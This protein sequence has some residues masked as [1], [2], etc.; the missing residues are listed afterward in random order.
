[1]G[2]KENFNQAVYELFGVGKNLT[3]PATDPVEDTTSIP[4]AVS[5]EVP[6]VQEPALAAKPTAVTYLAPGTVLEGTL[7]SKGDVEVAGDFKG[8][9]QADGNV[10]IH[11]N[12]HGNM[13]ASDLNI[14]DC[15]L[16]GDVKA[17]G[18]V[19]ISETA[20]VNGNIWAKNLTCSGNITG[21]LNIQ[22]MAIF[23][24]HAKVTGSIITGTMSMACGAIMK[25]NLEMRGSSQSGKK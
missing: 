18:N 23:N 3:Q 25:G 21:D 14:M 9:I 19:T 7:K 13:S 2:K 1:M 16:T 20:V 6:V 12:I 24:E 11:S 17:T 22:D 10:T 5:E 4:E 15:C 8:D